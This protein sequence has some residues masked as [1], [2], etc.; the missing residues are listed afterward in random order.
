MQTKNLKRKGFTLVELVIVVAVIA[1]LSAILIP[2]IGCFVE[3]AKETNDMATVR[4]LNVALVE[5]GAEHSAP[6]T[7]TEA[8]AAMNRKGYDIEKLNPRSSGEILWDSVNNRF[9]LRNKEGKDVYRDNTG[10]AAEGAVLWKVVGKDE[11]LSEI[12][13]NYLKEDYILNET[14][15]LSPT[16]GLDVGKRTDIVS[17]NYSATGKNVVIRTAGG[18]LSVS[19]QTGSVTHYGLADKVI[20][21][22]INDKSYHENGYVTGYLEVKNG[23]VVLENGSSVSILAVNGTS[24][25]VDQNNGAELF[26]AVPV[27]E[28]TTIDTSKIKL[29]DKVSVSNTA[30][31]TESLAKMNYGGGDGS[32]NSAYEL[33]TA[34]HLAAFAKDVSE[35]KFTSYVYA[36]LCADIDISGMGWAPIGNAEHPFNGSFD[37]QNHTINGLTNKGYEPSAKLWGITST[38]KNTGS[39]YGLFGVI[40]T[41]G[42][43]S[44]YDKIV[45]KNINF[46]NVNIVSDEFNMAGTLLG[47]D[48]V[49]AKIK[50][51][52][53][54]E[55]YTGDI[56]IAN[57]KTNGTIVCNNDSTIGGVVG[58]IYTKGTA[59]VKTCENSVIITAKEIGKYAG[60]IGFTTANIVIDDCKNM[61]AITLSAT[62]D[63]AD[64]FVAGIATAGKNPNIVIKNC[65]NAAKL[66]SK[67]YMAHLLQHAGLQ[68][69][70]ITAENCTASAGTLYYDDAIIE[71]Q[72]NRNG[73]RSWTNKVKD[74]DGKYIV[75]VIDAARFGYTDATGEYALGSN[76][77][78]ENSKWTTAE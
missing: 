8:L 64:S 22:N 76:S 3:Q 48:V 51:K 67:G 24:V 70:K 32:Q 35:G 34:S 45:L 2:T 29:S 56:E 44:A 31:S 7:M 4:L 39:A 65:D 46:T 75:R 10:K 41:V 11:T 63:Y 42:Q 5:D 52:S 30:V 25:T 58:K 1:V 12:Y 50:D 71:Y 15:T 18:T 43:S 38:A 21:E 28:G 27:G 23:H 54:N 62:T 36:K 6:E 20:V 77:V 69:T 14:K 26:K 68:I 19:D 55:H 66:T 9:L 40:G 17:I 13:S 33:Y 47:A 61:G 60:I 37:G 74:S 59:T 57:I 53:V 16:T 49:A 73:M 78:Y 72:N